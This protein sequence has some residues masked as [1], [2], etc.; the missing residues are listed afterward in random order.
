MSTAEWFGLL[1]LSKYYVRKT[2]LA[3]PDPNLPSIYPIASRR[4]ENDAIN[5]TGNITGDYTWY[6][7]YNFEGTPNTHGK[8]LRVYLLVC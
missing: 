2:L 3:G 6:R 4:I 8:E 5:R 7:L 1:P